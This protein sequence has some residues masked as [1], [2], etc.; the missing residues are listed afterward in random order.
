[1]MTKAR[2][3]QIS[4]ANTPYYQLICGTQPKLLIQIIGQ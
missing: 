4:L 2:K 1:M 3:Q